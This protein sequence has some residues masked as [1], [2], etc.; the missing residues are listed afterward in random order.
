MSCED[1]NTINEVYQ[2]RVCSDTKRYFRLL[3]SFRSDGTSDNPS[4]RGTQRV[5][6]DK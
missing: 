1:K 5:Q 6:L 4:G 3:F 2:T